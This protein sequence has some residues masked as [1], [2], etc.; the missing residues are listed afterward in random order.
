MWILWLWLILFFSIIFLEFWWTPFF[1]NSTGESWYP[2]FSPAA[3]GPIPGAGQLWLIG[4]AGKLLKLKRSGFPCGSV[5]FSGGT[6][7]VHQVDWE[8]YPSLRH[9]CRKH[10][11]NLGNCH[12]SGEVKD[13]RLHNYL[14]NDS[15]FRASDSQ[16]TREWYSWLMFIVLHVLFDHFITVLHGKK[17]IPITSKFLAIR[18]S[19][20]LGRRNFATL[21]QHDTMYLP[22]GHLYNMEMKA[23]NDHCH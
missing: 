15:T 3:S 1:G 4:G 2:W 9:T 19:R 6:W 20:T 17:N 12:V 8:I 18:L 10:W 5:W 23:A 16:N 7:S 14:D 13:L 21:F 22:L 11:M